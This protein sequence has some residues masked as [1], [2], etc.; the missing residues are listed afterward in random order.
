MQ[1]N[2]LSPEK[3]SL[4][5]GTELRLCVGAVPRQGHAKLYCSA[6]GIFFSLSSRGLNQIK[7]Y[8]VKNFKAKPNVHSYYPRMCGF[9]GNPYCHLL[10]AFAWIGPRRFNHECHH[11][12]GNHTDNR[13]CNLIWLT[14]A[15]HLRFDA[16]L[17]QGLVLERQDPTEIME[18][19]MTHHREF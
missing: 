5:D 19:D 12:N 10:V 16:A 1:K 3:I 15:D 9:I 11:L 14:H 2:E 17:R 6:T 8:H 7:C 18:A 4:P 13:A